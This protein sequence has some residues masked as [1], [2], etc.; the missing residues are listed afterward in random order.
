MDLPECPEGGTPT[1]A[2][3]AS[4][5]LPSP[6][7]WSTLENFRSVVVGG[8][9]K[10]TIQSPTGS[11]CPDRETLAAVSVCWAKDRFFGHLREAGPGQDPGGRWVLLAPAEL[12]SAIESR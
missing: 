2:G 3:H 4:P 9:M 1:N 7:G 8:S 12:D 10:S 5:S 6:Y 11:R